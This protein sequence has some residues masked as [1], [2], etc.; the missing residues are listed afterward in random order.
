MKTLKH[1]LILSALAV[2]FAACGDNENEEEKQKET[3][4]YEFTGNLSVSNGYK[5]DSINMNITVNHLKQMSDIYIN[6][7]T[8]S[9]KM[10]FVNVDLKE[11]PFTVN[12][13]DTLYAKDTVVPYWNG[14]AVE[15]MTLYNF[16]AKVNADSVSFSAQGG[17][18]S[19]E[20]E[21]ILLFQGVRNKH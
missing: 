16:N 4:E 7:I 1:I 17:V 10:P 20:G 6:R 15:N 8:F 9:E 14:G 19:Q 13:G 11:I 12:G 5:Q 3:T 2:G 21:N 18:V